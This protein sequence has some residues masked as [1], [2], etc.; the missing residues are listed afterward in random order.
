MIVGGLQILL[1]KRRLLLLIV[2]GVLH[3]LIYAGFSN[4]LPIILAY[5]DFSGGNRYRLLS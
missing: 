3:T 5:G 1:K 4:M 2:Y